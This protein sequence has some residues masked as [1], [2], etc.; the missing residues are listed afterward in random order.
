MNIWYL[1]IDCELAGDFPPAL[2]YSK[3]QGH[4]TFGVTRVA[5]KCS[6][7]EYKL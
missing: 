4:E 6:N 3:G 2:F 5:V 1:S 7:F